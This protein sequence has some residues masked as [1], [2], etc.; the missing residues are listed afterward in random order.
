M[1]QLYLKVRKLFTLFASCSLLAVCAQT[2]VKKNIPISGYEKQPVRTLTKAIHWEKNGEIETASKTKW[3]PYSLKEEVVE[4]FR[5]QKIGKISTTEVFLTKAQSEYVPKR[6]VRDNAKM[7]ISY[8]DKRFGINIGYIRAVEELK[9]GRII[10]TQRDQLVIYDSYFLNFYNCSEYF[11]EVMNLTVGRSGRLWI[12]TS[13]G[14]FYME[15]DRW[16]KVQLPVSA[17]IQNVFED[18]K[19]RIWIATLEDGILYY[20]NSGVYQFNESPFN[21]EVKDFEEDEQKRIWISLFVGV[22]CY[23]GKNVTYYHFKDPG[24]GQAC[25]LHFKDKVIYMGRHYGGLYAFKDNQWFQVDIGGIGSPF[26]MKTHE[27]KLWLSVFGQGIFC[28]NEDGTYYKF[29]IE[30]GFIDNNIWG[31]CF[32]G[33]GNIWVG[34]VRGLYCIQESHFKKLRNL[35]VL[36]G[37][38]DEQSFGDTTYYTRFSGSTV[39]SIGK[40]V[41]TL[42]FDNN[43][44]IDR[45]TYAGYCVDSKTV[46]LNSHYYAFPVLEKNKLTHYEHSN[47]TLVSE[48]H[49]VTLDKYGRVWAI[50][51]TDKLK[52]LN[53]SRDTVFLFNQKNYLGNKLFYNILQTQNKETYLRSLEGFGVVKEKQIDFYSF[54]KKRVMKLCV[55][56]ENALWIFTKSSLIRYLNDNFKEFPFDNFELN[57]ISTAKAVG[58]GKF[59]LTSDE[60]VWDLTISNKKVQSVHLD[61]EYGEYLL[62][63]AHFVKRNDQLLYSSLTGIYE[64]EPNWNIK[65]KIAQKP[66]IELVLVDS[67][68]SSMN[69]IEVYP[70]TTLNFYLSDVNWGKNRQLSYRLTH[71]NSASAWNKLTLPELKLTN[72]RKGKYMLEFKSSNNSGV[73]K[74]NKFYFKVKPFWYNSPL[75]Y[76]TLILLAIVLFVRLYRWRS[77]LAKS[78]ELELAIIIEDKTKEI[79]TEKK[80]VEKELEAKGIL[81][82]EVNHRVMN[83]M[84]MVASVLELQSIRVS[85]EEG[86]ETLNVANQ[87]IK[88]LALAHQH[89]YKENQYEKINLK[90]YLEVILKNLTLQRSIEIDSLISEN[91]EI[92]IE[93]AQTVGLILNEL[94]SNSI[95]HAWPP[96]FQ[97]KKITLDFKQVESQYICKYRDNGKGLSDDFVVGNGIG[98]MLI[99]AFIERKLNGQKTIKNDN[100][101]FI[102]ISFAIS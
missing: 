27:D 52:Y 20:D 31:M 80:L 53:P 99:D 60:G 91:I 19:G 54:P 94:I 32:D 81:L 24:K 12:S 67:V 76:L 70:N 8:L 96:D 59:L 2:V 44:Q 41:Y 40:E 68:A 35:S 1:N 3:T 18:S 7:N 74:V 69:D 72:L 55:D 58:K 37:Y 43:K 93:K 34:N 97:D 33:F 49:N 29:D 5:F 82:R 56:Q 57:S 50:T 101:Y 51:H 95:K 38:H 61:K 64:Y 85:S 42:R 46:W 47:S 36:L 6:L 16:F 9:D 62:G 17:V 79:A 10:F 75:F 13:N 15:N 73:S 86:R 14:C 89:F 63:G 100:G 88:A 78:R 21:T 65:P 48:T 77:N 30:D 11:G 22:L 23:D 87:R 102:E 84:Q 90:N 28:L 39:R 4:G 25:D 66:R 98:K 71:K 83:N 92:P 26:V 45:S